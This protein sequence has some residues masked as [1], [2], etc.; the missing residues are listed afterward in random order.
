MALEKYPV[1]VSKYE[2]DMYSVRHCHRS[3]AVTKGN[4]I[5]DKVEKE[6]PEKKYISTYKTG[7]KNS[8]VLNSQLVQKQ[9]SLMIETAF[10]DY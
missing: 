2:Y 5:T 1:S 9:C 6:I 8:F 7:I 10:G 4:Q 3:L